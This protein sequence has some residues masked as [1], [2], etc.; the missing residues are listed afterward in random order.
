MIMK[1][2]EKCSSS[3]LDYKIDC[4]ILEQSTAQLS[5]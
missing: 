2:E 4:H 1:R 5:K 3:T